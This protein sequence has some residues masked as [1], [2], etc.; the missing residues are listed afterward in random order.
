MKI[1]NVKYLNSTPSVL[2]IIFFEYDRSKSYI[3]L[4]TFHWRNNTCT[5]RVSCYLWHTSFVLLQLFSTFQTLKYFPT[6]RNGKLRRYKGP[7]R[8]KCPFNELNDEDDSV[9]KTSVVAKSGGKLMAGL[10]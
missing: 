1:A 5:V 10:K 9:T 3:P 4:H 7:F 8:Y 6:M 2:T